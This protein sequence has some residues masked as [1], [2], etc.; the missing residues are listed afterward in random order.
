MIRPY[1][2]NACDGPPTALP[3]IIVRIRHIYKL[4]KAANK[5]VREY[6]QAGGIVP[7]IGSADITDN[8]NK[9]LVDVCAGLVFENDKLIWHM[10]S[11][12]KVY[13]LE[14][15][16]EIEFEETPDVLMVDGR[17]ADGRPFAEKTL[18]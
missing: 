6:V 1:I 18:F 13:G 3:L 2:A 7:C 5:H 4:P 15:A 14:D 17:R 9:G 11:V 10:G 12:E 8:L 16:I